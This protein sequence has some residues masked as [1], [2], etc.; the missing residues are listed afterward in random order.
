MRGNWCPSVRIEA[1]GLKPTDTTEDDMTATTSPRTDRTGA[2]RFSQGIEQL[3]DTRE[4]R[5]IGRFSRGIE[6]TPD[7][8]AKTMP[9]RFSQGI[10]ALPDTPEKRAVGRYSRGIEHAALPTG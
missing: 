1:D 9:R 6:R 5:R 3:P 10:E 8:P 7:T 4:K 2:G